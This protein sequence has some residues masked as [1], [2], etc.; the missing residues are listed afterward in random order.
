MADEFENTRKYMVV[1]KLRYGETVHYEMD[2]GEGT[3]G[4]HG[5][6]A[7]SAAVGGKRQ[8]SMDWR[9]RRALIW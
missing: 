4:V 7:D 9:L 6:A 8:F 3:G 2:L 1:Q 5:A